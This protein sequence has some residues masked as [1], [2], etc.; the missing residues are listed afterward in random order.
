LGCIGPPC[1]DPAH[2][3]PVALAGG[4]WTQAANQLDQFFGQISVTPP[5]SS[6]CAYYNTSFGTIAPGLMLGEIDDAATGG[7][8]ANFGGASA[9]ST[10]VATTTPLTV[11]A[12]FEPGN[13]VNHALIVRIADNCGAGGNGAVGGGHFTLNGFA[14]DP[15]G[16][17]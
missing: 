13:A 7:A 12:L 8:L 5:N 14:L 11:T 3:A 17:S 1:P 9:S 6:S 16:V 2:G 4:A 10:P 15:V